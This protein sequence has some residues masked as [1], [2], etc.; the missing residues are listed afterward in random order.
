V[1]SPEASKSM[2]F[3]YHQAKEYVPLFLQILKNVGY[4]PENNLF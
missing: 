3:L 1:C 4:I 2:L